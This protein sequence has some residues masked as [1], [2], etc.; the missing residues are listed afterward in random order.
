MKAILKI[1]VVMVM[2]LTLGFL[3]TSSAYALNVDEIIN[4]EGDTFEAIEGEVA[5]VGSSAVSLGM[6]IASVLIALSIIILG[7]TFIWSKNATK[8]QEGQERL[9]YIIGGVLLISGASFI[10]SKLV[11][12][13]SSFGG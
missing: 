13:G 7:A 3:G 6:T 10:I 12:I 8:R 2:V 11:E 4:G 1:T 9:L 5:S